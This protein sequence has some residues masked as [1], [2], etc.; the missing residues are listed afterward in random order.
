MTF[1]AV[2]CSA[3]GLRSSCLAPDR[4]KDA[5]GKVNTIRPI[6]MR[7]NNA[8]IGQMVAS[9]PHR[10]RLFLVAWFGPGRKNHSGALS[11]KDWT[12]QWNPTSKQ[13]APGTGNTR[14]R[15]RSRR[16]VTEVRPALSFAFPPPLSTPKQRAM[17]VQ[18]RD[19]LCRHRNRCPWVDGAGTVRALI[20]GRRVATPGTCL[21]NFCEPRASVHAA[22]GIPV[23]QRPGA[24]E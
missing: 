22:D 9:Q 14:A 20:A 23:A 17:R 12:G 1:T 5:G 10:A 15:L 19:G 11:Q 6:K 16:T 2:S 21:R 4:I 18:P 8:L 13:Q 3:S 7:H 24:Q